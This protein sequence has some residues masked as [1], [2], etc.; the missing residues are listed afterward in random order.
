MVENE[1]SMIH[2]ATISV[3]STIWFKGAQRLNFSDV[4]KFIEEYLGYEETKKT[5]K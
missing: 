2:T 5:K 4:R 3:T 1:I